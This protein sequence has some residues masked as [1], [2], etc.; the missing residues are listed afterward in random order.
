MEDIY[1]AALILGE[2]KP[3]SKLPSQVFCLDIV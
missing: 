2:V 1:L 3:S